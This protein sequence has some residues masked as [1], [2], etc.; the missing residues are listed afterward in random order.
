MSVRTKLLAGFG[1]VIL[2]F[3]GL[4]VHHLSVI[5]GS[6]ETTRELRR[7]GGRMEAT[8]GRYLRVLDRVEE[9]ASK[10]WVTRDSGYADRY[11]AARDSVAGMIEE[12]EETPLT[13]AE[14]GPVRELR[15]AWA[16]GEALPSRLPEWLSGLPAGAASDTVAALR[17]RVRRLRGRTRAVNRASRDAIRSRVEA[18]AEA[19]GRAETLSWLFLAVGLLAAGAAAW[20]AVRSILRGLGRLRDGTRAVA[21]GDFEH[22]I[23][24]DG[25]DEFAELAGAFNAM[26]ARLGEVDR[27]KRDFLSQVSHDLKSP[28]VS[29]REIDMLLLDEVP[30][31]LS[32]DQRRLLEMSLRSSER[33]AAMI[34]RLLDLARMEADAVSYGPERVDVGELAREVAEEIRPRLRGGDRTLEVEVAGGP[35]GGP[36]ALVDRDRTVQV[37]QNLLDNALE[38]APEGGR[39][40]VR[41]EGR[42]GP[43]A[44]PD[45]AAARPPGGDGG[46]PGDD[47]PPSGDSGGSGPGP[48]P[49]FV[50]TVA[51]DGPGVPAGERAGIFERFRQGGDGASGGGVGLG[52]TLCREIA[53]AHGGTIWVEESEEGGGLFRV[54]RPLE[55]PAGTPAAEGAPPAADTAPAGAEEAP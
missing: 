21:D 18:S 43:P 11:A 28:L 17:E 24:T 23:R 33:L 44:M 54:L 7:L 14:R 26:T 2:V 10:Y 49:W 25:E 38:H 47:G 30:G 37:L 40:R 41:V 46:A 1:A 27:L 39:I 6:A 32:D 13:D 12:L 45:W 8:S 48:A 3:T 35:A 20:W 51:D 52:L 42:D 9:T 55:P 50:V 31:E 16:G 15:A 19:V 53:E 34:D 5:R 29:V 36:V 22:R 4:A